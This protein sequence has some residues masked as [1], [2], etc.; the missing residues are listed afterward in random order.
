MPKN[1]DGFGGQNIDSE[2]PV[3]FRVDRENCVGLRELP[4]YPRVWD[5][6]HRPKEFDFG[7][8]SVT[9]NGDLSLL[10]YQGDYFLSL[11]KIIHELGHPLQEKFCN[12]LRGVDP[13][14]YQNDPKL[15]YLSKMDASTRGWQRLERFCPDV[16]G[17]IESDFKQFASKKGWRDFSTF[18]QFYEDA[19]GQNSPVEKIAGVVSSTLTSDAGE[20]KIHKHWEETLR[21][22]GVVEDFT[23]INQVRTGEMVDEEMV[24]DIFEAIGNGVLEEL[25][26]KG[27]K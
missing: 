21:D 5:K 14:A 2:K 23:R 9:G 8:G 27:E 24:R 19:F 12:K 6:L 16:L 1:Y 22:K 20:K 13:S 11:A 4:E 3:E 25:K 10:Y 26:A 17:R 18:Q 7:V 15:Y